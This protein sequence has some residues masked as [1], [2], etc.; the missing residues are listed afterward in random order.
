MTSQ[1]YEVPYLSIDQIRRS[2]IEYFKGHGHRVFD[3]SSLVPKEDPT[4]LFTNSGMNQFKAVFLGDNRENLTRAVDAQKCLRVSGKHNDL[5][6]VGRDG[7]HHTFFE[8]MGNWSFGDYFKR[9]AIRWAW[10]LLTEVWKLPKNRLF[11]TVYKDDDEAFQLWCDETDIDRTHILR[12]TDDNFWEMG[13][14]GPCGPSSEIVFDTGDLATQKELH[15][16]P[17]HGVNGKDDRFLEIWNLV[18]IQQERMTD[19]SLRRLSQNHVDTGAGLERLSAVIQ[20]CTSNYQTDIFK[21]LIEE[22]SKLSQVPY[23]EGEEG[24]AHR[25]IADHI[26]AVSF[27]IVDGASPGNEGRGYVIRRIL[28]RASRFAHSIGQ[29]QPFLYKLVPML[30]KLMGEA[31]PEL[32]QR[33]DYV[34][35]VIQAEEKRFLQ[36]LDQGLSLLSKLTKQL[37]KE[38]KKSISGVDVFTLYDTYGFPADLTRIIAEEQGLSID[39]QGYQVAMEEQKERGRQFAKFDNTLANDESWVLLKDSRDTEFVGYKQASCE[40]HTTRYREDKDTVFVCLDKTPF[41]AEAGGQIG[42]VGTLS[43]DDVELTVLDTFKAFDMVIHRCALKHGLLS[44]DSIRTLQAHI[45]ERSRFL[46]AR[47]H[48][49]THLLHAALRQVLG[50][51]V[52]QQGSY[53]GPDRLRFDFTF[54]RKVSDDEIIL[55][56]NIVNEQIQKNAP[57][58]TEVK[59]FNDAK[60]EGAV[61]LFGEKYG[62]KVRVLTMGSFSKELC[63]GTHAQATGDIGLFKIVSESSVAAGVR[64]IEALA[65]APAFEKLRK[66]SQLVSHLANTFKTPVTQ[67]GQKISE[68]QLHIKTLEKELQEFKS[69]EQSQNIEKLLSK[70]KTFGSL[71]S[72]VS[73]VSTWMEADRFTTFANELQARLDKDVA[74]LTHVS[75]GSLSIMVLV[76][77]GALNALK[78]PDLMKVLNEVSHGKGGGRPDRAQGGSQNIEKESLVL[79]KA[80]A[81]LKEHFH[82]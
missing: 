29:K 80:E 28:R 12:F 27:A 3:S 47:H 14:T 22:I 63:G 53:V 40:A 50:E 54:G 19:G 32:K 58:Q 43:N 62:D 30:V 61:A 42:D 36:T 46:T 11:A 18:F 81:F 39:E 75:A 13:P 44:K 25:V 1:K 34:V 74:V 78:A 33:S 38:G 5:D 55:V 69:R 37:A 8:M 60:K 48:S 31:Y 73:S 21:T 82:K 23:G 70:R 41:Y 20:K 76:G 26:R 7:R 15:L 79:E 10:E 6:E 16:H 9:D 56:E 66:D 17:V 59:N 2:Y 49:V 35:Q 52:S 64:R 77:K 68:M 51:H 72:V 45:D 4:I 67:V 24:L 57:I 65:A 71:H